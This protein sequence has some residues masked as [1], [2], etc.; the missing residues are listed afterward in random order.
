MNLSSH[1]N[2]YIHFYINLSINLSMNV[3]IQ[4]DCAACSLVVRSLVVSELAAAEGSGAAAA[5]GLGQW[6]WNQ[7]RRSA[8]G[9]C[10]APEMLSAVKALQPARNRFL[11]HLLA[12]CLWLQAR[13]VQDFPVPLSLWFNGQQPYVNAW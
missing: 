9:D 13:M 3:I 7:P 2:V 5:S 8:A 1:L 12:D 11:Y 10:P 4:L 6:V